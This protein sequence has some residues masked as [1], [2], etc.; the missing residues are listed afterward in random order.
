MR[1]HAATEAVRYA[2]V[3]R[4]RRHR[5]PVGARRAGALRA[6]I[7]TAGL[8]ASLGP[9]GCHLVEEAEAATRSTSLFHVSPNDLRVAYEPGAEEMARI[10]EAAMPNAVETVER[11]LNAPL[12]IPIHVYVCATLDTFAKFTASPRAGGHT[13]N[14]RVFISPKPENTQE[15]L[16]RILMHELTHLH[17]G[18]KRGLLSGRVP[19]WFDE[20]LAVA[21]SGGGGAEGVSD[22]DLRR[23]I[24]EGRTFSPETGGSKGASSYGLDAHAFY[25]QAGMF[26]GYLWSLDERSFRALL[27]AIEDGDAFGARGVPSEDECFGSWGWPPVDCI[28]ESCARV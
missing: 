4:D 7:V 11:Q 13:I 14:H 1:Q 6:F 19:V 10:I 25:G 3:V 23:A 16:P 5:L 18:Q 27:R 9:S 8:I 28:S 21:V 24:S 15:R 26:V 12:G 20:G 22:E 2:F 17:L